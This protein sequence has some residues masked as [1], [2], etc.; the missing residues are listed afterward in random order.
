M[1]AFI[2]F[3]QAPFCHENSK[4]IILSSQSCDNLLRC[5]TKILELKCVC[6]VQGWSMSKD[7]NIHA[8]SSEKNN[9]KLEKN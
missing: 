8:V 5:T 3:F 6:C 2:D 4:K 9:F 1:A 7:I